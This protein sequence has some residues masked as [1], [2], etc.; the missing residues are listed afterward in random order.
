MNKRIPVYVRVSVCGTKKV[1][2]NIQYIEKLGADIIVC[3]LLYYYPV[4][5][6]REQLTFFER[7]VDSTN[8]PI[9][10]YSIPYS[11]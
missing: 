6:K 4:N 3:T 7:V 9:M 11:F 5:D 1:I 10:L 8:L 2:K